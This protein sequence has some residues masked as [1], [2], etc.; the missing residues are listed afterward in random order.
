MNMLLHALLGCCENEI[1]NFA[2]IGNERSMAGCDGAGL[3]ASTPSHPALAVRID[4]PIML[5][6][7]IPRGKLLPG[8]WTRF[9]CEAADVGRLLDGS[10]DTGACRVNIFTKGPVKCVRI[11]DYRIL[12]IRWNTR[13]GGLCRRKLSVDFKQRFALS[14]NSAGNVD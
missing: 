7:K 9:L 6:D 11:D 1:S 5:R 3:G 8:W 13:L 12:S 4:T 10:Q 2:C 14:G